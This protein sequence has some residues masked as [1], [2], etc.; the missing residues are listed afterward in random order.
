M[1]NFHLPTQPTPREGCSSISS[2]ESKGG[3][4][5]W[6]IYKQTFNRTNAK[7]CTRERRRAIRPNADSR[8]KT[9][10][11]ASINSPRHPSQYSPLSHQRNPKK[12][13]QQ[14][15]AFV[16]VCC[17]V[18]G[19][20]VHL[21]AG[22]LIGS[23]QR[24]NHHA[25][26]S[27]DRAQTHTFFSLGLVDGWVRSDRI[28]HYHMHITVSKVCRCAAKWRREKAKASSSVVLGAEGF[29]A[30]VSAGR[31]RR[32]LRSSSSSSSGE[33]TDDSAQQQQHE[34][35]LSQFLIVI[36][37]KTVVEE[38]SLLRSF[39]RVVRR[40]SRSGSNFCF[41]TPKR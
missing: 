8:V 5:R 41:L 6:L 4:G 14:A 19:D 12:Q 38:T 20:V 34:K 21:G 15:L 33:V 35:L 13:Q 18:V 37:A 39:V 11:R 40:R 17:C 10:T 27:D 32:R 25:K 26:E 30:C 3:G 7:V 28:H 2:P 22:G 1:K 31:Y 36:S 29:A 23:F 24:E 16:V 9:E